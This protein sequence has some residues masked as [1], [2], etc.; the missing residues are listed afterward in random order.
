MSAKITL[1]PDVVTV[2]PPG[3]RSSRTAPANRMRSWPSHSSKSGPGVTATSVPTRPSRSV[4]FAR[5]SGGRSAAVI[6]RRSSGGRSSASSARSSAG[7]SAAASSMLGA[8]AREH[9]KLGV[10][11][12]WHRVEDRQRRADDRIA[13]V[14]GVQRGDDRG[15]LRDVVDRDVRAARDAGEPVAEVVGS[16]APSSRGSR[17]RR[18][19]RSAALSCRTRTDRARCSAPRSRSPRARPPR[20][21]RTRRAGGGTRTRARRR[22]RTATRRPPARAPRA[23]ARAPAAP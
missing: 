23:A 21:P 16:R 12:G 6:A 2:P 1:G 18:A 20:R 15:D 19:S 8:Q 11:V 4:S 7:T 13:I 17:A 22:A 9:A 5:S 3:R 14:R 10:L